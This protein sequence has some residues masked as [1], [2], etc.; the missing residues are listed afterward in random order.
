MKSTPL[1]LTL[2]ALALFGAGCGGDD[3]EGAET[4]ATATQPAARGYDETISAVNDVCK[5]ANE[6]VDPI[7]EKITGEPKNDAPLI[8]QI[9]EVNE[10]HI[11]ELGQIEPDPK[12]ADA[13][14]TFTESI[15]AQ[16][17]A[18]RAAQEAAASGD[19]DAYNQA[20]AGVGAADKTSTAAAKALGAKDC[21]QNP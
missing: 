16:Q 10:E 1:L 11:A 9:V 19:K 6:A 3:E 4:T 14:D 2:G 13:F 18:T 21:A 7:G 5:S 15:D 20:L 17:A 12:L 8:G